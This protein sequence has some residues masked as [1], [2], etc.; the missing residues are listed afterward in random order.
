MKNESE[1]NYDLINDLYLSWL[2]E[3]DP[4]MQRKK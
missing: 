3:Q 1:I 2:N 4:F